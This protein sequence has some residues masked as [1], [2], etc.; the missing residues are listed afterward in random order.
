M[1][2]PYW[3][4]PASGCLAIGSSE[5]ALGI[6]SSVGCSGS[7][8]VG[9]FVAALGSFVGFAVE[10]GS[11]VAAV[12]R[13]V[14][15][16]VE[17]GSFAVVVAAAVGVAVAGSAVGN[18]AAVGTLVGSAADSAATGTF[19]SGFAHCWFA[20]GLLS[21]LLAGFRCTSVSSEEEKH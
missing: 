3:I 12:G 17:A 20:M 2:L 1:E 14:A 21:S 16:A 15:F 6:G 18:F 19:G 4:E 7:A 10:V 9:S 8:E 5:V 13:S 11:S